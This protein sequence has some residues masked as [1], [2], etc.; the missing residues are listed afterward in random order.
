VELS[1]LTYQ[2][3]GPERFPFPEEGQFQKWRKS[4]SHSCRGGEESRTIILANKK[5]RRIKNRGSE[6]DKTR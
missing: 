6:I 3:P 4:F 2:R 5:E 1:R